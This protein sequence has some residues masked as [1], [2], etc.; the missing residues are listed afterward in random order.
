MTQDDGEKSPGARRDT[1]ASRVKN[2][3]EA[4]WNDAPRISARTLQ[5]LGE[6]GINLSLDIYGE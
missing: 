5:T 6:R 1:S 2:G 3:G 4:R